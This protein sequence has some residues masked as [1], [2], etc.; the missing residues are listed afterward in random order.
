MCVTPIELK[1]VSAVVTGR[2]NKEIAE[3][4]NLSE[5]GVKLHLSSIFDKLGVS[6]RVELALWAIHQRSPGYGRQRRRR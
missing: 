4:C 3:S 1:I 2:P 5:D 6:T